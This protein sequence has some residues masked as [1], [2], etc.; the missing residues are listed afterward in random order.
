[1]EPG[2]SCNSRTGSTEALWLV[3]LRRKSASRRGIGGELR[4]LTGRTS[5][6]STRGLWSDNTL[7]TESKSKAARVAPPLAER[8]SSSRPVRAAP[9]LG[10]R[11]SSSRPARVAPPVRRRLTAKTLAK[12]TEAGQHRKILFD[13][14][15]GKWKESRFRERVQLQRLATQQ[16]RG[17]IRT[18][19]LQILGSACSTCGPR[20]R[21]A[22]EAA[23]PVR[24]SACASLETARGPAGAEEE[25]R[26]W[27]GTP[28]STKST[29]SSST[30]SLRWQRLRLRSYKGRFS[31]SVC[32]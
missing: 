22:T 12:A 8:S 15:Q 6:C 1:M 31:D 29:G 30:T 21:I 25:T 32:N 16:L 20:R 24:H 11:S 17:S 27:R 13:F 19:F 2:P 18:S 28:Y 3:L 4:R 26:E 7:K 23:R 10:E 9:P 14:V 5:L